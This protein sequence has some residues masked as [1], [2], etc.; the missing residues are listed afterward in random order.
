MTQKF[1]L[2]WFANLTVDDW[3][4][5]DHAPEAPW[6]GKFYIELAKALEAAKF[7]FLFFA[8]T[9]SV[10][11]VYDGSYA[12][13]LA[14][15]LNAPIH[16]PL[17]LVAAIGTHTSRLGLVSTLTTTYYPPYLLAR[18]TA[19]LDHLTGGRLGWNIVTGG[20][21]G[22]A[23]NFG[24]EL[25]AHDD[26]Y[27][28][29]D[30][31]TTLVRELWNSW[32]P[33]SVALDRD[34]HVYADHN[35]VHRIDF[36]GE[37]YASK[38]LLTTVPSPQGGPV[39]FQAGGSP[40][41]R[42][43]AAKYA[44]AI[45]AHGSDT[46]K[47]AEYRDDVRARATAYGRDPDQVK[48]LFAVS[49]IVGSTDDEARR[50]RHEWTH[51][52][53]YI[54][55]KLETVGMYTGIDFTAYDLDAPLPERL[56]AHGSISSLEVFLAGGSTL[57][58]MAANYAFDDRLVGSPATVADQLERVMG[59]TGGDGFIILSP[60][61]YLDRGYVDDIVGGLVPELQARGLVRDEYQHEHLRDT[62]L[63]F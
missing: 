31:Y 17:P 40:A 12:R 35:K 57:R 19:T 10:P 28:I 61:G 48:V 30:E 33:G 46:A 18:A 45:F 52:D 37:Y 24:I 51:N 55:R 43:F 5:P 29:A 49:P 36:Q 38:G 6:D 47:L 50:K 9:V 1:H 3:M 25:P 56:P 22:A 39:L 14:H 58:E 21:D 27:R 7:D 59:E 13:T 11:A 53:L 32:E 60:K 62:L 4:A 2:G 54:E 20:T 41:G 23:E 8:D 42:D 63:E 26:R 16:D 44:E 34:K 15:G